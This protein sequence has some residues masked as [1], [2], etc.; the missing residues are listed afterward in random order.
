[1]PRVDVVYSWEMGV[2]SASMEL[3]EVAKFIRDHKSFKILD[4][5]D[6][7]TSGEE[8]VDQFEWQQY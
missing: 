3:S 8:P 5:R 4:I 6:Y 7:S 1:M 2:S